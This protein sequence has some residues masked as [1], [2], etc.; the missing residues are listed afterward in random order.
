MNIENL[1]GGVN[2]LANDPIE[3]DLWL[4]CQKTENA[5]NGLFCFVLF[6]TC[7][8]DDEALFG[9]GKNMFFKVEPQFDT[10]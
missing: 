7:Q 10:L 9:D 3:R 1:D 8:E 5:N 6:S 2:R 4:Q